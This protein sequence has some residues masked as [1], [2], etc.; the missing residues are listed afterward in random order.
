M[1]F[2]FTHA[3]CSPLPVE[4]TTWNRA[5]SIK[6]SMDIGIS[7]LYHETCPDL[8]E[9]NTGTLALERPCSNMHK[10]SSII[11][12]AIILWNSLAT[13]VCQS[14]HSFKE[15]VMSHTYYFT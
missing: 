1:S 5:Y 15:I 2:Y 6:L 14:L 11:L 10:C 12:Y 13:S 3:T 4:D 8:S 7:L 9:I